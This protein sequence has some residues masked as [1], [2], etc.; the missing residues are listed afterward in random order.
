MLMLDST[1]MKF[2]MLL[3][4]KM[5]TIVSMINKTSESLNARIVFIFSILAFMSS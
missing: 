2:M 4:V 5:P 3:N 1:G